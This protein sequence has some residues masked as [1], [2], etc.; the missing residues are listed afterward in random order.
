[1]VVS[2]TGHYNGSLYNAG[3]NGYYWASTVNGSLSRSLY[4]SIYNA[5]MVSNNP[6]ANGFS[7]RCIKD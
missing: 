5:L 1:M 6:L 7:V 2:V 4:F 3:S